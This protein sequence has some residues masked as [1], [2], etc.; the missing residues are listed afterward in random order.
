MNI[1]RFLI[2]FVIVGLFCTGILTIFS[3][4]SA[5]ILDLQLN[6]NL[7]SAVIKQFAYGLISLIVSFYVYRL[8]YK[9]FLRNSSFFFIIFTILLFLILIPGIGKEVNGSR[10]WFSIAGV[11][12]QPSEIFKYVL[13]CFFIENSV[14]IRLRENYFINFLMLIAKCLIPLS[15]ILLEPNNGTFA[16]MGISILVLCFLFDYPMKYW[17]TPL[18]VCITLGLVFAIQ[19]PYVQSRL[20]VYF[21]PELDLRGRGHQPYQAKIAVGSG[22]LFGKGPGKSLQKLSY[23]P[24]AQ[25]DYIAAIIGEEYGFIG[26]F[27]LIMFYS[28]FTYSGYLIACS[29]PTL[30]GSCLAVGITF[31]IS[32]QAFLNLAVV[33]GLL[34]STGLNLPFISQGGTSLIANAIGIALLLN[35]SKNLT[36]RSVEAS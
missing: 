34:P 10:R 23:L 21:H 33:S 32:F 20:K 12:F 17:L 27:T 14:K 31:L 1:A 7:N 9:F 4:S 19:L 30:E 13:L 35:I 25:N 16:V 2:F 5:E 8:G 3:A 36:Y 15:F 24:E 29:H 6:R 26:I 28:L 22:G 18:I 11:S